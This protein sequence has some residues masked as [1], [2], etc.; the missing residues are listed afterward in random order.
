MDRLLRP[1]KL[2]KDPSSSTASKDWLHWLR[3]FENF[4][5]VLPLPREG[6]NRL[7]VLTNYVRPRIFEYI[8][9]C[10]TYDEAIGA[11]KAQYVKPANEVFARHLLATRRQKSGETLDDILQALKYLSKVCNFQYVTEIVYRDEAVWD[12]FITGLLSN[13]TRQRLL[14]NNALDLSTMFT[15]APSFDAAQRSSES[16]NSSNHQSPTTC[17]SLVPAPTRAMAPAHLL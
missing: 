9:H 1:E 5:T 12:A 14:E 13:T 15:Q 16:Y 7:L 3:T 6:L 8:E 17:H 11:L 2:D 10:L 4:L